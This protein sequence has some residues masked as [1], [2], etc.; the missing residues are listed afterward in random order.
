MRTNENSLKNLKPFKKGKVK[1]GGTK[2]GSKHL[3]TLI[4]EMLAK[5]AST[6]L[7]TTDKNKEFLKLFIK[8]ILRKRNKFLN[9][10]IVPF[11]KLFSERYLTTGSV[12]G[13]STSK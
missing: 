9:L 4:K 10:S 11:V 12:I 5:N 3:K 13:P 1:T 6:F 2:K 7:V 8:L